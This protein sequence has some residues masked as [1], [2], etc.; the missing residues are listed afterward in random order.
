MGV[1]LHFFM[2]Q[3][4]IHVKTSSTIVLFTLGS[5]A[6]VFSPSCEIL[7]V[8]RNGILRILTHSF[9]FQS[10][11]LATPSG[12]W[13]IYRFLKDISIY[14][15]QRD[16]NKMFWFNIWYFHF[17]RLTKFVFEYPMRTGNYFRCVSKL[18]Y[19]WKI[20]IDKTIRFWAIILRP[21]TVR[22]STFG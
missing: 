6:G 7:E 21:S 2:W 13:Y 11:S 22:Q 15:E 18:F 1:K 12:G 9:E 10:H 16:I 14:I 5:V 19:V 20:F 4:K 8:L 3:T 17:W